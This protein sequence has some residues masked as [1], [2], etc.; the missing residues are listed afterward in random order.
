MV[1]CS[2]YINKYSFDHL[3]SPAL[4]SKKKP[5][6]LIKLLKIS[7]TTSDFIKNNCNRPE[8]KTKSPPTSGGLFLLQKPT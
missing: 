2:Y 4:T 1:T 7:I 3:N 5:F 8:I 6:T